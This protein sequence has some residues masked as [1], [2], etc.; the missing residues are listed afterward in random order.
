MTVKTLTIN[1]QLVSAYEEQTILEAAKDAKIH[2]PTLCHL[3]GVSDVGACRLCLVEVAGSPKL[4]A[5]CVTKVTEGM[6]VRTNSERLQQYRRMI[7][8]MLFAEGNHV[9]SVCVANGN[10][11]LQN[12]G[13]EMGMDHVRLEYQFPNRKVDASHE[14]FGVDHNRCVLCTRCIRVCD[15]IEGAHTWDMAGRGSNSF[16]ITDLNQ[17]W[18][19]SQSCTSCGKCVNACPTG[20]IFHQGSSVGE[21]KHDRSK[22][23]FII[24]ARE[25]KQWIV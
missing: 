1:E 8:E 10:C 25:K 4:Q 14:R 17:P 24:T 2:I 7:V 13:I 3:E 9:C 16:V 23:E 12:L 19:T 20:A 22:L 6:E 11:E 5:A 15:E 21:M 18:G